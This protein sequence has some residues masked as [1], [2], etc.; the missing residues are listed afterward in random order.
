MSSLIPYI[1][2]SGVPVVVLV[3]GLES[4]GLPLPGETLMIAL[5][6]AAGAEHIDVAGLFFAVWAG[7]I[8]GDNIGYFI[9]RRYGKRA[10]L[11]FGRP[12][13]LTEARLARFEAHF[14]RYGV[15]VVLIARFFIILRQ[16]NGI[17]AG[18]LELPWWRFLA[19]NMIGA[20]LWVGFW[21]YASSY[22]SS[23]FVGLAQRLHGLKL[24]LLAVIAI[25]AV[26]AAIILHRRL[27]G[28]RE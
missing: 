6:T 24:V 26:G 25:A 2:Q 18:S 9:G 5:G 11:K 15:F 19:A 28:P 13:G 1:V 22:F 23:H 8:I 16:L 21:L 27:R 12:S 17:I 20:G 3:V 14:Q 7:A 4:L 10:I